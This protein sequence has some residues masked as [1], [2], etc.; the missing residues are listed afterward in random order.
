M[1][2]V[3]ILEFMTSYFQAENFTE[4]CEI[5]ENSVSDIFHAQINFAMATLKL[6]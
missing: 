5:F 3:K 6:K 4:T 1:Q 2:I